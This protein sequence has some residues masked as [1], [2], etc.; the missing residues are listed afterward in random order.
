MPLT[1]LILESV[2]NRRRGAAMLL[3]SGAIMLAGACTSSTSAGTTTGAAV[4]TS[5]AADSSPAA[6]ASSASDGRKPC[7][8]PTAMSGFLKLDSASAAGGGTS[9]N[10]TI[11]TCSVDP[12]D[13][14]DVDY[15]PIRTATV[16]V[17]AGAQIQVLMPDNNLQTVSGSWLVGHQLVNTPYF[18]YQDDARHE[19][20][21]MQQIYHP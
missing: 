14:E 2:M 6:P 20:T 18:T 11:M 5:A 12:A 17:H 15:T 9:L 3:G 21:A 16:Q 19:I 7:S 10:I 1:I 4:A 13:D 8:H